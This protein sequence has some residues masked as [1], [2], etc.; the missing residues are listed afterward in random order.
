MRNSHSVHITNIDLSKTDVLLI[1]PAVHRES[2]SHFLHSDSSAFPSLRIDLQAYDETSDS[3]VGTC[4][5]LKHFAQRIQQDFVILP[6][7]LIPDPA[8]SLTRLL[9]KFRTE[10]T[11]DGSIATAYFYEP[12]RPEKGTIPDEWGVD[13]TAV[14]ILWEEKSGTLLYVDTPDELDKNGEELEISMGLMCR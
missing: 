10:T 3:S 9:N 11:Y 14:P 7:D 5:V 8:L 2:I 12:R 4:T 6:C 13:S 1:C